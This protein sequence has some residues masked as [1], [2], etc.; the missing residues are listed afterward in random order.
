MIRIVKPIDKLNL[1]TDI[2]FSISGTKREDYKFIFNEYGIKNN[3]SNSPTDGDLKKILQSASNEILFK[4]ADDLNMS[5]SQINK[6]DIPNQHFNPSS[7]DL[8]EMI[9]LIESFFDSVP[10]N[11]IAMLQIL[12]MINKIHPEGSE[13]WNDIRK[14]KLEKINS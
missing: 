10:A 2:L 5:T 13:F 11:S 1:I 3:L 8:K 7:K 14:R 12:P 4:I 6:E 9:N